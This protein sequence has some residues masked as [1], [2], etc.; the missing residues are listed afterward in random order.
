M[1]DFEPNDQ[2]HPPHVKRPTPPPCLFGHCLFGWL[3]CWSDSLTFYLTK[4]CV[5][6]DL[7]PYDRGSQMSLACAVY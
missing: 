5:S 1:E 2:I 3:V 4:V 7:W 6:S